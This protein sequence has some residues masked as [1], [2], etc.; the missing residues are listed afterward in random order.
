MGGWG[1]WG[2]GGGFQ[3]G[4]WGKSVGLWP[5]GLESFRDLRKIEGLNPRARGG[6]T[7]VHATKPCHGAR[8]LPEWK[9][10]SLRPSG[11]R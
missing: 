6:L 9:D 11:H 8:R 4:V 5:S 3:V 1:G 2:G 10:R 7:K